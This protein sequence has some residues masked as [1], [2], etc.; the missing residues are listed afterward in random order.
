MSNHSS[1][2][3]G[4]FEIKISRDLTPGTVLNVHSN[5]IDEL[6]CR[7]PSSVIKLKGKIKIMCFPNFDYGFEYVIKKKNF[8]VFHD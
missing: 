5:V 2:Q 3:Q 6:H 7:G 1:K 8:F 4:T